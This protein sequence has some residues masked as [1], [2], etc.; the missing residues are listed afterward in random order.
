ADMGYGLRPESG[1]AR[2]DLHSAGST[3]APLLDFFTY[4]PVDHNYP[5]IGITNLNTKHVPVLAAILQSALKKD[6]DTAA[7][8]NPF[9]VVSS[10][11]ATAAANAI[12]TA[13][14]AQPALNRSDIA[15]LT[16]AAAGSIGTAGFAAG[17]ETEK[18]PEAIARALSEMT[19]TR[20]WNLMIDC[21]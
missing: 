21:V 16:S 3:D 2:L 7:L 4:N 20:T 10:S 15:R 1:F 5:R 17:E 8:P 18:V 13:T 19:Q 12:V 6:L 9:P 14:T 11:E